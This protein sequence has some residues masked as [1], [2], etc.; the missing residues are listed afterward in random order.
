VQ[1]KKTVLYDGIYW[2]PPTPYKWKFEHPTEYPISHRI[3]ECHVGMSSEEG[4]INT[5]RDFADWII[6]RIKKNGY[7]VIQLM[8]IMEHVYYGSFGYHVTNFFAVC[9]R[10]GTPD[11]FKYLVDKAHENGMMVVIDC[12]HSHASNNVMDGINYFDGTDHQYFHSGPK[13][14]HKLWDSRLFNFSHWE[15]L[16]F[17][18]SDLRF[19]M[20]EYKI[21]GFRFDAV[22]CIMFTHHGIHMSFSGH[23]HEYFG[24]NADNEGIV[25]LMMANDL[26]HRLN[27]NAITIAEDVSGMPTLCRPVTEGG[28]GFDYRLNMS[29]P[30][31]W[32]KL[33]KEVKD[34]DWNMGN[35]TYTLTNRRYNEKCVAYVESHDQAIVG[36]KTISMWLFDKEIY[37]GMSLKKPPSLIIDRGMS[38]HKMLRLITFALGGDA[39]LNFMG[40]EFGHPEWIDFPRPGNGWSY[41]YCRRQ[42]HLVDDPNL[43]YHQLNNFDI[44]LMDLDK[45]YKLLVNQHQFI[46]LAH[47]S[48]KVIVF[49]KG[50]LL[51]I[52]NFHPT[53]VFFITL[54]NIKKSYEHYRVGTKWASDHRVV[55]NTDRWSFGGRDRIKE[56]MNFPY[57]NDGWCNRPHSIK[58]YIPARS[59]IVL[60]AL[61]SLQKYME[62]PGDAKS[63]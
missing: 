31:K 36:D 11:D 15:V 44:A 5:Y 52:F 28:L 60:I 55:L 13:G 18:L 33:L 22:T 37:D 4:K 6:P 45:K 39:Y 47:E 42:W 1:D 63:S 23:Y 46:T 35:I 54:T 24:G 43:R 14:Y 29:V 20:D 51:F 30:D 62:K 58:L 56:D 17:L 26:I 25:F 38:L 32:I 50:D 40:N 2:D 3:Y 19:Y 7:N 21:D 41:H 16:R 59:A 49:E 8:A 12:I 53:K 27:P 34:D 9:S 61:E 48:D 57:I 10:F